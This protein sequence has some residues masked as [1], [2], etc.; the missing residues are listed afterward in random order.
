MNCEYHFCNDLGQNVYVAFTIDVFVRT[1]CWLAYQPGIA[2]RFGT[3]ALE[4]R[5]KRQQ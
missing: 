3:D 4:Q 1:C 2:Y 5:I